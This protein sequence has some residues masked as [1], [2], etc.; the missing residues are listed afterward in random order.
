MARAAGQFEH[1]PFGHWP[2]AHDGQP[3]PLPRL[4]NRPHGISSVVSCALVTGSGGIFPGSACTG[5]RAGTGAGAGGTGIGLGGGC[6]VGSQG[7]G[8][9]QGQAACCWQPLLRPKMRHRAWAVEV[10]AST[11]RTVTMAPTERRVRLPTCPPW[12]LAVSS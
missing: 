9:W 10:T 2:L 1:C 11:S 4:K 5:A 3:P 7:Q 8:C 6:G 12:P